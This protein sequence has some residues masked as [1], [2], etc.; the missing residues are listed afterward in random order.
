MFSRHTI[1]VL[2]RW[3]YSC[4]FLQHHSKEGKTATTLFILRRP[5]TALR[6]IGSYR[7]NNDIFKVIHYKHYVKF[8][9][10]Y[11]N[12][13]VQQLRIFHLASWNY[14]IAHLQSLLSDVQLRIAC[15]LPLTY[16]SFIFECSKISWLLASRVF[17]ER[18]AFLHRFVSYLRSR[19]HWKQQQ[20][21]LI[22]HQNN[23]LSAQYGV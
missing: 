1:D 6:P 14:S 15:A 9:L 13:V 12:L 19:R 23:R 11:I 2:R 18:Y 10:S 4:Q 20:N 16:N 22:R 21:R 5:Y 8:D 7:I 17:S 3:L